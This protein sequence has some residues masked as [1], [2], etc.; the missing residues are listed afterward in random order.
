VVLHL[1]HSASACHAFLVEVEANTRSDPGPHDGEEMRYVISGTVIFTVGDREYVVPAGG[2]LRH[3]STLP[4]GFRTTDGP[5]TFITF[6]LSHEY[7]I[8]AL[9]AGPSEGEGGSRLD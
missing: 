9:F 7:D 4:H 6:V 2:T 3:I 8:R 5:A 1:L